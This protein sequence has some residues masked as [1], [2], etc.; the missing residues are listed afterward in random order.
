VNCED[1]GL[2]ERLQKELEDY[3]ND[4]EIWTDSLEE[5]SEI[6]DA[7]GPAENNKLNG[8][9]ILDIGTDCVKP[10][11]IAL[12]FKPDKIVGINEDLSYS[13]T[14]DI[15]QK[16]KLF[17]ETRIKFYN[18]SL[19]DKETLDRILKKEKV[20]KGFDFILVSKTLHHFRTGKCV[21][22]HKCRE[23]EKCCKY[24]FE[25]QNIF[26]GL[27]RLGNRVIIYEFF[28]PNETDDD[29]IRGRGGYFTTKEWI[30]MFKA[31]SEKYTVE[32]IRPKRF[33]LNKKT[34]N[35][36]DLILRQVDTICF[37]VENELKNPEK[38]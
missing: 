34:L 32:F 35:E 14:S 31:L 25:T 2:I 36:V 4:L 11:Y 17:A 10:L 21:K 38:S 27:L 3:K 19:F 12:K 13:Y 1:N 16:S 7:F 18:C 28:D 22:R 9:T 29:K 8:K 6:E 30:D 33:S 37:Y 24:R 15:E 5:L 20:D 23:D 26:K